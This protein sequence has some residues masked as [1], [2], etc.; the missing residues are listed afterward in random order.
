[1][2][3]Q[4]TP[5]SQNNFEKEQSW[6]T[7]TYWFQNLLQSY[8]NQK[9]DT[10]RKTDIY[11]NWIELRAQKLKL[12]YMVK[13]FLTRVSR[14]FNGEGTVF[15]TNGAGKTEWPHAIDKSWTL[16]T[17]YTN[18]NS[19]WIQGLNV[20]PKTIKFLKENIGQ[21]LHDTEFGNYFFNRTPKEK[22]TK[23]KINKLDF[24]IFF[25]CVYQ[26]MNRVKRQPTECDKILVSH[27]SDK[28]LI[29]RI[30]RELLK[31]Q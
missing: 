2:E 21:K 30:Y 31:T 15:P 16:L 10:S 22:A 29:H 11:T 27:I 4:A 28:G 17:L 23:E 19:K 18:I 8:S 6:S 7:H 14:P 5:N 25:K 12:T 24:M 1:M 13:W 26:N 3:S 9:C 20:T